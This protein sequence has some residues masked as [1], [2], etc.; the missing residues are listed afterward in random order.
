MGIFLA[1]AGPDYDAFPEV[2]K[3]FVQALPPRQGK[4]S[5]A[6]IAVAVHS[7]DGNPQDALRAYVQPLRALASCDVVPVLLGDG[8]P[9]GPGIFTMADG[10][11]VGGGL[12][13]ADQAVAVDE[14]TAV[15]LSGAG[16]EHFQVIGGGNCCDI[17]RAGEGCS[18]AVRPAGT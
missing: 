1:G 4:D 13:P 10:I 15:L 6:R 17:R 7:R 16:A 5:P 18:V 12:T 9:A 8:N 2:F 11:V 14:D 3:H